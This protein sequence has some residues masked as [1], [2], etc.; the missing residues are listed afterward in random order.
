[1]NNTHD[2]HETDI[3]ATLFLNTQ[4]NQSRYNRANLQGEVARLRKALEE[5]AAHA[6]TD[7]CQFN[8]SDDPCGCED[9]CA[10]IA[11]AAL[12]GKDG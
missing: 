5:I 3:R 4:L 2:P 8:A 9:G 12:E 6:H 1:M 10:E 11:R 7:K